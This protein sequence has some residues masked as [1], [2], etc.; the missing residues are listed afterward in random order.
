MCSLKISES[1][2]FGAAIF[3]VLSAF[4]WG[5]SAVL[6]APQAIHDGGKNMQNFLAKIG[7]LNS[8]AAGLTAMAALLGGLAAYFDAMGK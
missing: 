4:F 8:S 6:K 5:W 2:S 7:K 3:G 1:L